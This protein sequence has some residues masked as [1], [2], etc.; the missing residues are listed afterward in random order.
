L[1][2]YPFFFAMTDGSRGVILTDCLPL[3]GDLK[4]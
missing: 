2:T 1:L 3:G 4:R